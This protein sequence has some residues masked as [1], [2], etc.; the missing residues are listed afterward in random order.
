[1]N[2]DIVKDLMLLYI[3]GC[4]SEKSAATVKDHISNCPECKQVYEAMKKPMGNLENTYI[5]KSFHRVTE[6]KASIMQSLLLFVSFALIVLG[7]TLEAATPYG[8]KNGAWALVLILPATAFMLSLPNWFFVRVYK[9]R[10]QFSIA[11]LVITLVL[12]LIAYTWAFIHYGY[13]L[14]IQLPVYLVAGI[15]LTITF[16]FL[17][18]FLSN[19]YA[20]MLGKE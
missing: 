20:W 7:V 17:S 8:D 6:W 4:C 3:D 2:C 19:K 18:K 15:V 16:G 13:D 11:S 14:I 5:V 9:S 12:D 10:K 1:M